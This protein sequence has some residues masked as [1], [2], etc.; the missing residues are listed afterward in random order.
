MSTPKHA[1]G[2][3]KV[4]IFILMGLIVSSLFGYVLPKAFQPVT[5]N[6]T[7]AEESIALPPHPLTGSSDNVVICGND[8]SEVHEI[9][10][11]GASDERLLNTNIA[12]LKQIVWARLQT[13]S[14]TASQPNCPNTSPTCT[15]DQ[16]STDTQY[17]VTQGGEYRIF[18]QYNDN[19]T[20][21]FYFNVYANGLNPSAV[22]TNIDCGSDGSITINNVPSS[23]EFSINSGATWQDS[24]VFTIT[25]VNTYNVQLRRKNDTGGCLFEVNDIAVANN[26][27]DATATVIPISCNNAK[28]GI[29][30]DISQ[31]SSA[32]V[33]TISQGG[34]LINSSGP[35]TNSTYTFND[36]D[37]GTFD[38]EVT[39][40]SVSSCTWMASQTLPAFNPVQPNAV[41]TKN[42]DCA[43]GVI[44]V[45]QTGGTAPYEY[46]LNGSAT[47]TAF[48]SGNQSLIP[49]TTAGNYTVT[50]RDN[51]GCTIDSAPVTV[52][53]EPEIV[54]TVASNDITCNG[55]DDGTITVD[56]TNTQG[57][58]ITYSND[59]G[60]NFQT[61]NVFS[62]LASGT[63]N[64]VVKKS[65]S[66][67]SC[68]LI[69]GDITISTSPSFIIAAS[70]TQQIDCTNG[71]ATI[72]ASV[73]S[74]GTAP[75]EYSTNG[76]N[77]QTSTDFTGLGAGDFTITARDANGC[78]STIDQTVS[79]GSNA[80]DLTFVTSSVDCSTGAT[81]VQVAVQGGQS[82]FTYRITAP[83]VIN[84]P[85]DTFI[86]LAPNTYTFEVTANDGCIIV[87]NF[88]VPEPNAIQITASVTNNVSCFAPGTSDGVVDLAVNNF[89]TSYSITVE[90]G[91]GNPT[92]I[93]D[94]SG[95]TGS[96]YSI[97]GLWADTFTIYVSDAS[98]VC[99][100]PIVVT[101]EAPPSALVVDSHSVTHMNCGTPGSVT[102]EA[103]GGWGNY[104]YTVEQPD[105][106][107]TP[108]QSSK[109]ITGLT[110]AGIHT[111]NVRDVNGCL[112]DTTTFDLED[113][114]GPPSVVDQAASNYCYSSS[115]LGELKIDVT[116]NGALPYFYVV[117]NG[118]PMPVIGG[119]FTLS[120]LTPATYEVKVIGN[121][122]CETIVA[123]TQI[124]G[125]LF[126]LAAITKPLGCGA[127]PDAIIEV[128][129][130]EGY[131]PYT[132]RVDSG[133]GYGPA[134]MPFSTG[135]AGTYT[136]EVTDDK[137]CTFITD[138]VNVTSSPAMTTSHNIANTACG[139]DGT[140]SIELVAQGGTPPFTYSFDG[141]PF[142]AQTLYTGLDAT[143]YNYSIRDALGC[144]ILDV[145]A[146]V[147]AE[148]AITADV[149]K[150]DISCNPV[151][152]PGGN[153]WGNTKIENI[154]NATGLLNIKLIRVS[155][156][157]AHVAGT[158]RYW[159]YRNYENVDM[160]LPAHA[161]DGFDIRMYWPHHFYVE[162]SDERGCVYESDLFEIT[163][164]PL[165]W[166]QKAETDLDQ[167][168]ANGATFEVEVGD[169]VGL[170]GPFSYR[171]WPYDENNPPGWRSFEVPAENEAFGEDVD[172]GGNERDFRVSGLLFGV[173]YAIVL[174][175]DATG[176]QRWRSLGI[177]HA[178]EAPANNIDVVST[179][180][181]LSCY[182]GDDGRVRFTVSGADDTGV[183]DALGNS[184]F[185]GPDG[186]R[187]V[188][189]S[190][191]HTSDIGPGHDS[192]P[193]I[194]S[195]RQNG[196]FT[197]S[198][199]GDFDIDV[200][201]LKL[202]WYVVEIETESG[203]R[204]GNRFLIYR[205]RT[206]LTLELDQYVS[207]TCNLGSQIAV[208]ARGGWN[209]QRYFN[210]RN[211]LDQ[212]GWHEY[213][214]AFVVDGTDP[215]T[216][217]ATAWSAN[218]FQTVTPTA[219]D[220][221]NNIYQ[222]YVR[223]GGG[224]IAGL[225]T[226]IT[227]TYDNEPVIDNIDVTNRCTSTN[228]IYNVVATLSDQGTNPVNGT[229]DFIWDGEVTNT[230]TKQLGP[231]NHTLEVRDENGCSV[232]EN[233]FIYPQMVSSARTTEIEPCA[234]PNSGEITIDVYGGSL[235]YTFERIDN[236]ETNTTGLFAGLTHSTAYDFRITDNN[237]GCPVQTVTGI[238]ID[239]PVQPDFMIESVE[240]VTCNGADDGKIVVSQTPAADNLDVTYDYSLDGVT[241]QASN[242][243]ENL[244]P[245]SYTNIS[246]RSSKN[247]IQVLTTTT[248]NEPTQLVLAAPT[249]SPF[250]CTA[251][252][253]LGMATITASIN[254]GG[255][256]PTGTA[257]YNYSFNGSSFSTTTSFDIAYLTTAQTVTIDV[258][259]G[260]GCTD[261]TTATI[262]AA[263]KVTATI[264]VTQD[265]DC[266]DDAVFNV[267]GA[268]G[269]GIPNYETREL[270]SGN[271]INGTGNGTITIEEGK[272]GT[273]VYEL[274]DTATG[275]TAQV[276][277]TI[278]PFDTIE[279]AATKLKDINCFG[280]TDGGL[281]FT[282]TG[283]S[284]PYVYDIYNNNAPTV[285]ILNGSSNTSMGP[286]SIN[287]LGA[288]TY[289]VVV[290]A[291]NA[292]KCDAESNH[293]TIQS[294]STALDF[295][296]EITQ[297][298]SCAPG[299]DAQVTATPV[300]GWTG[301][302]FELVDPAFPGTPIQ[303]F[304]PN[305]VFSG[306][307]SGI[308]YELTLRDSG[309][310]NNV[311]Q[312]V[313]IPTIDAIVT[314][315]ASTNP[316][317]PGETDGSITVTASR[318]FGNGHT[319]FQYI[320]NNI[321]DGVSSVPQSSNVFNNLIES[322]YSVT[323]TDGR[324]CDITT[325]AID[326]ID[327]AEVTVDAAITQEPS[328][329]P[330][331]GEIT[332]SATGGSGT[333]EYSLVPA[334]ATS[335][336]SSPIFSNLGPGP[337]EFLARDQL[338]GCVSPISVIRTINVVD[339]LVVTV[340]DTNTTINCFGE[341]DAVLVAEATGGLGGYT[342]ELQDGS[343]AV[344]VPAQGSGIFEN[345]GA[346]T[347][348]IRALSGSDCE[349]ISANINIIEPPL[350]EATLSDQ[351]DVQCYGE[352]DGT[353]TI[354]VS[355][356]VTPYNYILSTEPQKTVT[357]NFFENLDV[358]SY[359]VVVQDANG[360]DIEVPIVISGPTEA[361]AMDITR[362][363]DE[364]CSSDDNG[365]IEVRITGGTAPYEYSLQ[366]SNGPFTAV[367]DPNALILDNLDGGAYLIYIRD[368][369]GCTENMLQEIMIGADLTAS[370]E[371]IYECR[372]GQPYTSTTI[373]IEDQSVIG[374]VMYAL[375]SEDVANAQDSPVFENIAP[376]THYISIL[377]SGGCIER[378]DNIEIDAPD[379]LI[380][381][382]QP[383]GINEIKVEATGGDGNYT[384]YFNDDS[385]S[386]GSY[387]INHTDTYVVRVV[388]G[389][390]CET[391][392]DVY[393]E[394]ID[395]EIPNFFTPDGDGVRD[396]WV[397]KNSEGFPNMYV[398]I[399]DRYG[400]QIKIFVGQGEWD[401]TY[402]K[403]DL[404]TGDYWYVIKLNGPNDERE[405]VGHMTI[406]R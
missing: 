341:M 143:S 263:T 223:D 54:Y 64:V 316:T 324:G 17:N 58:S 5:E 206:R 333:Y 131:P 399:Y 35:I 379:P 160:S 253:G 277:Y 14:C 186:N 260:N 56:V 164:P 402:Q 381:T 259:D 193:W 314:S 357:T 194:P 397:I 283:Y 15:W 163:Q 11:C 42:I 109:T 371:T 313:T 388:D 365:L 122:G 346:G 27:I 318:E 87:R 390:G 269:T 329:T 405:F 383:G 197:D 177:V 48:T 117:N 10:L 104:T 319:N 245:G 273:Y 310:C 368:A 9:Y 359:T 40:A 281:E 330:N 132:Y 37:A 270:P 236:G 255:G 406:Y 264:V 153:I 317:C 133:S 304:D 151:V 216:L 63:Y 99:P 46:S 354:T 176:C 385:S 261:Q 252:N 355:G 374:E 167:S 124:S 219:Y 243:F 267:M 387:F 102:I 276:S 295:T 395:I 22:V 156:P 96:T 155:S 91:T 289:F 162:I 123:D 108:F 77:F 192:H 119:T 69:H 320:L 150:T 175:D 144:E 239:A 2:S 375:D 233:I 189:W 325:V 268:D 207:A 398:S 81:D 4:S 115:T 294:P 111:I 403:A 88:T 345:L 221:T 214:Y 258:I 302:E 349:D 50:V 149:S 372:D 287:T 376:G 34:S 79:A 213:E 202:A 112:V 180:Q 72:S 356:G 126:A 232:T 142:T 311:M 71:S 127:S 61:S 20:E 141:S 285:S 248:I 53:D 343:G 286:V 222:V 323:V 134:T 60:S 229:P 200:T 278:A 98:S 241:Y 238:T 195:Y 113:R 190:I 179:P 106:T 188:K 391:V 187:T 74:G 16:L 107:F 249:V 161:S 251:D 290:D 280:N 321:T 291:T 328:C 293:I 55:N 47:F 242:V 82:P 322:Q 138:P 209:D 262:P 65:K 170:V 66:G 95:L 38:I 265:M 338:N 312:I 288:D 234:P 347:Y 145:V 401:G 118:T 158:A 105:A 136:F 363:D 353:A 90:D 36:L 30:I 225:G 83:S 93:H 394:F 28:G 23:Y 24:N 246:V 297:Q 7:V 303:V 137:G 300:G 348:R 92:G 18:I 284:G 135:T 97:T 12:N 369:N 140:G 49:I 13:A 227:I 199:T 393:L 43:N 130:E 215:A 392:I 275:C 307:T 6:N 173:S 309:G 185:S 33:Y 373:T 244:A 31:A 361:L 26:S 296:F 62:N 84:A 210:I 21:R 339:P 389:K 240:H 335:W 308:N 380:L 201:N 306:L 29:Q 257:P 254:D 298:L 198:G 337:Y 75:F 19:S 89:D 228:E 404:P 129:P 211:K 272:P 220:G 315:E 305:N 165:P 114:G 169:P 224:C 340:D 174:R 183:T 110:Q 57:Y 191:R 205:P 152:P 59:G 51:N 80:S 360:C 70:V 67:S 146:I 45:T 86:G 358:G 32:Y 336:V 178:P 172:V 3:K 366:D 226:P 52:I 68:D 378:L 103:S 73:T 1:N 342:Y 8:G 362:V 364:V 203:C 344:L 171:I 274:T 237:S 139:K 44:T 41:V 331:Q 352:A 208:T 94:A 271:L 128:T 212:A 292:P 182:T 204:S 217:P 154:Q 282:V 351:Q 384:Y 332:L 250:T 382:S 218:S 148:A 101:V 299:N 396:T 125:Q 230:A 25:T 231:G 166:I 386:E 76:V 116:D 326:L 266:D 159:T 256:T 184:D 279:V 196:V 78:T 157:A 120:N 247:C 121:N 39:L 370:Y 168:C 334:T 400:R 327:P 147:G 85:G 377:H 235:D 367:A 181:S 100:K 301:Y 350:L